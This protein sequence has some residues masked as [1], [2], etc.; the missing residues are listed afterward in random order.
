MLDFEALRQGKI[1]IIEPVLSAELPVTVVL[2]T[3]LWGEGLS[4]PQ[5]ILVS[6]TFFGILLAMTTHHTHLHYHRRIFEKGV[7][8]AIIGSI[9]M[10]GVNFLMGASSQTTSP[11]MAIWF[12]NIATLVLTT[13][14]LLW[15]REFLFTKD[16]KKHWK[17]ILGT[18]FLDNGAWTFYAFATSLIPIAIAT[19]ISES[20][21]ALSV[22]LGIFISR[23]K[24]KYHQIIGIIVAIA[25][26]IILS[27]VTGG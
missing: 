19:T 10:G 5:V 27:A 25:S 18:S 26:V 17:L 2:A 13:I 22:L 8:L 20:Y 15:R 1:A 14:A 4:L 6:S 23:E 9:V 12:T 11:L 3:F 21:I 24:L 16:F 7:F